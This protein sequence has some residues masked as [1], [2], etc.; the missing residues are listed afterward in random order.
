[1]SVQSSTVQ[2]YK[3]LVVF[4][5]RLKAECAQQRRETNGSS[6]LVTSAQ[7]LTRGLLIGVNGIL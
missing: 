7:L 3:L 6:Y 2:S 5:F 1:M 4:V